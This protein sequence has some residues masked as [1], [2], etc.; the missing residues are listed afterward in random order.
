MSV[1]LDIHIEDALTRLEE[2]LWTT[3]NNSFLGRSFI[4]DGQPNV[5]IDGREYREVFASDKYDSIIHFHAEP[6]RQLNTI[7]HYEADV[8]IM[9]AVNLS[10]IYGNDT[11]AVEQAHLAVN[12]VIKYTS[13]QINRITTDIDAYGIYDLT[14][15]QTKQFN[16]QPFYVFR[17]E[18]TVRY[19]VNNNCAYVEPKQTYELVL[20]IGIGGNVSISE[21]PYTEGTYEL[22][23]NS[24]I[25]ISA[26]PSSGN[27]FTSWDI[28]GATNTE[29]PLSLKIT[30]DYAIT[31]TFETA[32]LTTFMDILTT[33]P[34]K[35]VNEW[36]ATNSDGDADN[37][38]VYKNQLMGNFTDRGSSIIHSSIPYNNSPSF[39]FIGIPQITDVGSTVCGRSRGNNLNPEFTFNTNANNTLSIVA[40]TDTGT[41]ALITGNTINKTDLHHI[42]FSVIDST[43]TLSIYVKNLITGVE[44]TE[45]TPYTG[46]L[47]DNTAN[48]VV[49]VVGSNSP[50]N[51]I[52]QYIGKIAKYNINNG[53]RI[54]Y[55]TNKNGIDIFDS[56][57]NRI[58]DGVF[59]NVSVDNFYSFKY[60]KSSEPYELTK[61]VSIYSDNT[62]P[63]DSDLYINVVYSED[64]TPALS[65]PPTGYSLV[66][67]F[68]AGSGLIKGVSNTIT[69]NNSTE[70]ESFAAKYPFF[71]TGVA[72]SYEQIR[73]WDT[74]EEIIK[75][76]DDDSVSQLILKQ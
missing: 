5:Y 52:A 2:N 55:L 19:S 60:P 65:E 42:I 17:L 47:L 7:D 31:P 59:Q 39:E 30:K 56:S 73:A 26:N 67:H 32:V 34:Q 14:D 62:A 13:F 27:S 41:Q 23:A 68:P 74:N 9:V 57:V 10:K 3:Y 37:Y 8:Y 21:S 25:A 49:T 51:L 38:G 43:K 66:G 69:F 1:G 11:R 54:V 48:G 16:M 72:Y 36:I 63:T 61:G 64:G 53:D 70:L 44:F 71:D 22:D 35:V 40:Y 46:T 58:N 29:N 24:C 6:P 15:K 20:N 45:T 76:E 33:A 75:V 28:N 4:I 12:N 18:T 50:N